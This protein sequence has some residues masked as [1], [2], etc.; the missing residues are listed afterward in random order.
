M[1]PGESYCN[2]TRIQAG[3]KYIPRRALALLL[4]LQRKPLAGHPSSIQLS[5]ALQQL[6]HPVT[7]V[8]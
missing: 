7:S 8:Q 1:M 4:E 6:L 5:T 3:P 2:V